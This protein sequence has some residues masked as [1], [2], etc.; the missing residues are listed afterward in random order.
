MKIIIAVNQHNVIGVGD[1]LLEHIPEDLQ[2]FKQ[3][4]TNQ[5]V[6]MGWNTFKSLNRISGL[7]DR[8]N[9][10][11]TRKSAE[12]WSNLQQEGFVGHNVHR[13]AD[14][15]DIRKM[16]RDTPGGVFIIGGA[17]LYNHAI[18]HGYVDEIIVT[19]IQQAQPVDPLEPNVIKIFHDLYNFEK[20][21]EQQEADGVSVWFCNELIEKQLYQNS[22]V[23]G[24]VSEFVHNPETDWRG[25]TPNGTMYRFVTYFALY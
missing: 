7:P 21:N 5:T 6:V 15:E 24:F 12:E 11:L 13:I 3:I 18:S 1:Q 4:T 10:V 20:F 14:W 17:A 2:R 22:M 25:P 23:C 19:Q 16:D 8:E 9:Y